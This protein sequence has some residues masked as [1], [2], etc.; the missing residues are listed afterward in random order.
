VLA[1]C[2]PIGGACIAVTDR[3]GG[4]SPE[5]YATLNLADH[6]GD[7]PSNVARNRELVRAELGLDA[8]VFARQVHGRDVAVVSGPTP[9]P[10]TADVLV[11]TTRRV[12]V[13]ALVADCTPVLLVAP[14]DGIVATAHAGRRG[15]TNGVVL[16]AVDAMR[17]LGADSIV[18]R[19]GPSICPRCYEVPEE[20]REDFAASHPVARAV[21]A[22]G[23]PALDIAAG[24]VAQLATLVD[25]VRWL[26]GCSRESA[27]L[28][29]FRREGTTGRYAGLAW[30]T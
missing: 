3:H 27:D 11:T 25:D 17:D 22:F 6:V 14:D 26:P 15:L 1:W 29:S 12:A 10:P 21:D 16:A 19:V 4:V 28:F 13:A 7:D 20:L 5:P 30:L 9:T 8:I 23:R 2:E 24:V 18:A